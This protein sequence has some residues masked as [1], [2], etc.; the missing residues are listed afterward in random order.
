MSMSTKAVRIMPYGSR[1][2]NDV[3]VLVSDPSGHF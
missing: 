3:Y 2:M 1:A